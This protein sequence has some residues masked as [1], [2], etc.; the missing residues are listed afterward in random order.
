MLEIKSRHLTWGGPITTYVLFPSFICQRATH[1]NIGK[2]INSKR[3]S[4]YSTSFLITKESYLKRAG[5][6]SFL[7]LII[8]QGVYPN[9]KVL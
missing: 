8:K 7:A 2:Y 6:H 3:Y 4:K 9:F 5:L 1:Y